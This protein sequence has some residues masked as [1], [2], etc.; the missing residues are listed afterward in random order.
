MIEIEK[1]VL[2]HPQHISQIEREGCF[3]KEQIIQD[4]YFDTEDYR[5]TKENVWLRCRDGVFELKRAVKKQ[6]GSIDRY[7]EIVDS[8]KIL[9]ALHLKSGSM[10]DVLSKNGI[11]PFCSFTT[12][13]K[14]YQWK[15]CTVDL[16]LADFGDLQYCVAEFELIVSAEKEIPEAERKITALLQ[17]LGIE[18]AKKVPAKLSYFLQ[19]KS[20]KH[21]EALVKA[22]VI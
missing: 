8:E 9:A 14:K 10:P 6:N 12:I 18:A 21:Y 13:R 5:Y 16:D 20:P 19:H 3:T 22:K 15:G 2:L 4:T 1:K 11:Q 7:E 17:E